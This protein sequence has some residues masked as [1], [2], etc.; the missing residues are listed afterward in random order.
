[1][2]RSS[3]WLNSGPRRR[4][5]PS[6]LSASRPLVLEERWQPSVRVGRWPLPECPR[7]PVSPWSPGQDPARAPLALPAPWPGARTRPG[8]RW[9]WGR[10]SGA[11]TWQRRL[12]PRWRSS[13]GRRSLPARAFF[14]GPGLGARPP[15]ITWPVEPGGQRARGGQIGLAPTLL[16]DRGRAHDLRARTGG[17]Q[18]GFELRV[19]LAVG[20]GQGTAVRFQLGTKRGRLFTAARLEVAWTHAAASRCLQAQADRFAPPAKD[21]LRPACV[22]RTKRRGALGRKGSP[23]RAAQQ[24]SGWLAPGQGGGS[25]SCGPRPQTFPLGACRFKPQ[26]GAL[27]Q[28]VFL[29]IIWERRKR[30]WGLRPCTKMIEKYRVN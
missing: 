20:I 27:F 1:M 17:S 18:R 5:Q 15:S 24:A 12:P 19:R 6:R 21:R 11:S 22:A 13:P 10:C 14:F 4:R 30:V 8:P 26:I 23:L 16:A 3:R 9:L 28:A 7:E 29:S 2:T 25:G